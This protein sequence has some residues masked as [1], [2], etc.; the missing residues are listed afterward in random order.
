MND[1][2]AAVLESAMKVITL[3]RQD[4]HGNAEDSFDAIAALWSVWLNVKITAYDV[5]MMMSLLKV[6]RARSNPMHTDNFIDLAGYAALAAEMVER[7]V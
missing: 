6:A 3:D 1:K 4:T 5:A 2:R 7:P